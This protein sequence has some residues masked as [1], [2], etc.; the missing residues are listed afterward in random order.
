MAVK[1]PMVPFHT[2][3]PDAHVQAPTT[4]SV[5]LAGIL[6]KVGGYGMIRVLIQIFPDFSL[7]YSPW[8]MILSVAAIIYASFVAMAQSDMKKMIAYSSIAHMGYVT[9]G[10]F[11]MNQLGL[12]GAMFQMISHG[13]ISA[14]L[15]LIVGMLYDRMHTKDIAAYGGVAAKMP[16]LA[17]FFMILVMGS[18]G[19]PGTS[20]FV[21]EF[22]SL[23]GMFKSNIYVASI[24]AFGVVL[25]A[26]YML[27]LY[28]NVMLG[29]ITK[30]SIA[31]MKDLGLHEIVVLI[32]IVLILIYIGV[33]PETIISIFRLEISNMV[34]N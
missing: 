24:A 3:L 9:A 19:L 15:F 31:Q 2:W 28:K 5:I 14:G 18:V 12:E 34:V 1:V 11:S 26:I 17:S 16:V 22:L 29:E 10:I 20:G 27:S 7:Y 23:A 30:D 25:G 13:I 4:G 21:G 8:V 33:Y 6:L 32:P